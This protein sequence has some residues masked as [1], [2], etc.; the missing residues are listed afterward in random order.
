MGK[1]KATKRPRAKRDVANQLIHRYGRALLLAYGPWLEAK[2]GVPAPLAKALEAAGRPVPAPIE[3][4]LLLDTGATRTC[5][6]CLAA[7]RLQLQPVGQVD[8]FGAGGAHK[9]PLY[10]AHLMIP[11]RDHRGLGTMLHAEV[12]CLGVPDLEKPALSTGGLSFEGR[13]MELIGLL[14]RDFLARTTFVYNGKEGHLQLT[15]DREWV[16]SLT[17]TPRS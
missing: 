5:I 15:F 14:G 9:N 6:S 17:A 12:P 13:P 7:D 3:G 8:G 10:F 2:W 4:C 16:R 1:G 11:I